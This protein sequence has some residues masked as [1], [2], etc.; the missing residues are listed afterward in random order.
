MLEVANG[1]FRPRLEVAGLIGFAAV[2]E[3]RKPRLDV[4][5]VFSLDSPADS[6]HGGHC[7]APE[8]G[9]A[10]RDQAAERCG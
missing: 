10:R 3:A 5:D 1:R 7:P 9:G 6:S 8:A 2:A 4:T